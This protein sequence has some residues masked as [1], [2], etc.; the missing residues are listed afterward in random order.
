[1]AGMI[2][3]P[4]LDA[5]RTSLS[6]AFQK[7]QSRAETSFKDVAT[8]VPSTSKS[9][10]Y[11][12][13]G[14]GSGFREW[15]GQRVFNRFK[16][17]KYEI[18]NK[19][20]EDSFAITRDEIE[21]D[22]VGTYAL[23]AE[24]HGYDAEV[25]PDELVFK[26]FQDG[27]SNTCYD[28]QYFFDSDHPVNDK[29]DGSGTDVSVSNIIEEVG[30][31]GP[32]WYLLDT[33][34]PLKPFIFQ[35]RRKVNFTHKNKPTDS[36]VFLLNEYQYGADCR[37]NAGYGFWQMAVAVK[38]PMN[39]ENV[40]KAIK[41]MRSYKADGGKPMG[42]G[43]SGLLAVV[44]IGLYDQAKKLSSRE[45]INEG[46]VTVSNEVKDMFKVLQPDFL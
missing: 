12:W 14:K 24:Q 22:E 20:W 3:Q 31:T 33:S 19:L 45:N 11:A 28:G 15:V 6:M 43:K 30:Y 35:E 9:N 4:Q 7:G 18:V 27:F 25:F 34:R 39:G 5:L 38:A 29:A 32:V 46:G 36:N 16:E 26:L 41:L 2:T 10:T 37:C 42:L 13:L 1:M 21:D 8:V 44:P 40:W 23:T 17:H